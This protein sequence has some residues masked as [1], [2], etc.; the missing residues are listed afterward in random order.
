MVTGE[1][2]T[3]GCSSGIDV[4]TGGWLGGG[5]LCCR[6]GWVEQGGCGYVPLERGTSTTRGEVGGE[7]GRSEGRDK[8]ERM[9]GWRKTGARP[10]DAA[11]NSGR[12]RRSRMG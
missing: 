5:S 8:S 10:E 9:L 12:T 7:G 3:A 1:K 11:A 6:Q 4:R 2:S